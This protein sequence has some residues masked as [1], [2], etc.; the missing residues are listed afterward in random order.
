MTAAYL[1]TRFSSKPSYQRF[2]SLFWMTRV[3]SMKPTRKGHHSYP[4]KHG[5]QPINLY[6]KTMN[7]AWPRSSISH[8]CPKGF[9][10]A[11]YQA[12]FR[13]Q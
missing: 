8:R 3:K 10:A 1:N 13:E 2:H 5:I 7:L 4:L 6:A 9:T 11:H 12:L